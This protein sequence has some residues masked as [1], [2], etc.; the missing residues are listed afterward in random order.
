ML[1][2]VDVLIGLTVVM[3]TLSMAVTVMTQFA[4]ATCGGGSS[5]CWGSSIRS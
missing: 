2:S 3:L 5:T 1:K 4:A